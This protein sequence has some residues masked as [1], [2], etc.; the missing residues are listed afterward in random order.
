M[1]INA[2]KNT[3]RQSESP[4]QIERRIL[5]R[6]TGALEAYSAYD[7]VTHPLERMEILSN[8][9]RDALAENQ[10]FWNVLKIDLAMPENQLSPD[11]RA[12]LLS[13]ALWVDRQTSAILGGKTGVMALV[14]INRSIVAGLSA[15]PAAPVAATAEPLPA[16][17]VLH[18]G[19]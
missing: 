3:I 15:S 19:G 17:Q 11:L 6:L 7:A 10:R 14:D 5:S 9:L 16:A 13:L 4:R 8:G 1:S 2:Y 18:Q 12:G